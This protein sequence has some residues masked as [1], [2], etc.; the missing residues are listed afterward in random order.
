MLVVS[1]TKVSEGC[2]LATK[3]KSHLVE[4]RIVVERDSVRA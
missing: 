2:D 1:H 3:G 4:M